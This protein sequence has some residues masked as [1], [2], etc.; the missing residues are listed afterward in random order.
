MIHVMAVAV[1]KGYPGVPVH[2]IWSREESVRQGRYR[3]LMGAYLKARLG[4]DGLPTALLARVSGGPGFYTMGL[5]DTALPL[6][7]PNVQIESSVVRD[8]H[9]KT[10]PLR[11]PGY[12]SNVFF[13]ESF[14][15]EL[16]ARCR[17]GPARLSHPHL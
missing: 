16:G 12:N 11:G 4:D 3:S 9:I 7:L 13:L 6:V 5:A 17:R 14:I 8:F 10:G 15:D 1:A 2:V